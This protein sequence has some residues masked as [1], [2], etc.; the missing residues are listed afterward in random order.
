MP[1]PFPI[2]ILTSNWSSPSRTM[3]QNLILNE[4]AASTALLRSI[5]RLA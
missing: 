5:L 1:I 2:I 4:V 3:F